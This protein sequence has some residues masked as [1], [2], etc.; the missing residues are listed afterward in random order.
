MIIVFIIAGVIL[1]IWMYCLYVGL[2]MKKNKVKE[3]FLSIDVQL[4]K[5][6]D[7][8]PNIIAIAKKFMEHERSIMEEITKLRAETLKLS[9]NYGNINE[10]IK[11]DKEISAKMNQ[12]FA[13]FEN[14]PQLKSDKTMLNTMKIYCD[15]EDHIAA[16]RRFFNS[17][18][19]ELKNAVEIF[20]SSIIA[21]MLN[22]KSTDFF[23]IEESDKSAV[24]AA[25]YFKSQT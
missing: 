18:V 5:R 6:Y 1:L 9:N 12:I 20:P 19:L 2:I 3:A 24:N 25:D 21:C 4:K 11:L 22:I 15:V 10:K 16:A 13:C 17:A 23:T 14:Y 8:L 7:L